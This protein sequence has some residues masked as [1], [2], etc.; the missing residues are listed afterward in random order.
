MRRL[1]IALLV[2]NIASLALFRIIW[3]ERRELGEAEKQLRVLHHMADRHKE[4]PLDGWETER[5]LAAGVAIAVRSP[6]LGDKWAPLESTLA[7]VRAGERERGLLHPSV[8]EAQE[9]VQGK[10]RDQDTLVPIVAYSL[11]LM[12]CGVLLAL[13]FKKFQ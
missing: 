5:V 2:C 13:L 9:V 6:L 7:H 1:L 8:P 3:L 11:L 12:H 10:A 4:I